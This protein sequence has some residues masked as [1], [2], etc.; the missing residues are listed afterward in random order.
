MPRAKKCA[1]RAA[2]K[3]S[4]PLVYGLN[5]RKIPIPSAYNRKHEGKA[6]ALVSTLAG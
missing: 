2:G 4:D 1:Q 3:H 5:G 6:A